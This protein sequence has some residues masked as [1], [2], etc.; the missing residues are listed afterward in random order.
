MYVKLHLDVNLGDGLSQILRPRSL[1]FLMLGVVGLFFFHFRV[2]RHPETTE[3]WFKPSF[4][5]AGS[6]LV[7]K[8]GEGART[9]SSLLMEKRSRHG[10]GASCI[11]VESGTP[12]PYSTFAKKRD[13]KIRMNTIFFFG[14]FGIKKSKSAEAFYSGDES[15]RFWSVMASN[16]S[17]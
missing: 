16:H 14:A 4:K 2:L 11:D 8:G 9:L 13:A 1:Y 12:P 7:N 17:K 3:K 15:T 10:V 5:E 6:K